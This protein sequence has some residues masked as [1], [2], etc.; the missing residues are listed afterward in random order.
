MVKHAANIIK[1]RSTRKG[2]PLN[3]FES[4]GF[5]YFTAAYSQM[6]EFNRNIYFYQPG[7]T[8]SLTVRY[9]YNKRL[10]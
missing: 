2:T 8:L 3:K 1:K 9:L 10:M 4:F 7:Q 5:R 6:N